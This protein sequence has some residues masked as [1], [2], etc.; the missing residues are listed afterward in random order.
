MDLIV[1]YD[2][3]SVEK[4]AE[5]TLA[6]FQGAIDSGV[7]V[8][9]TDLHITL[10]GI[11]VINHDTTTGR[12]HDKD[13]VV[14]QTN[15]SD[16]KKLTNKQD[17]SQEFLTFKELTQ[18]FTK[19]RND[20]KIMLDIKPFNSKSIFAKILKDLLDIKDD[21]QFWNSRIIFG[22]W[23]LDFYEFGY[24]T[25]LLENFQ[26][27]NIAI[28]SEISKQFI[29]YSQSVPKN[30]KLSAISI[31]DVSSW[32][33]DFKKFKKTVLDAN[34]IS[35]YL[36]T[37]NHPDDIK[38]AIQL[39]VGGIVT[40]DPVQ[41]IAEIKTAISRGPNAIIYKEPSLLTFEGLKSNVI[42]YL[43]KLFELIVLNEVHTYKIVQL[44]L[45]YTVK[46]VINH[47]KRE[48]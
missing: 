14:S 21:L 41:V 44:V 17:S 16:L 13:L 18:W 10:D 23:R 38:K 2:Q 34:N 15:L 1:H 45:G 4:Y 22:L 39:G 46:Y 47:S 3:D 42:F 33:S 19:Q 27:I 43:F 37:V 48:K 28:S 40:D 32:S 36:W 7:D 35:L 11:I 20:I 24:T 8:L 30:Y 25:G 29:S 31:L 6:A 12:V 26:I 9:E 5:N